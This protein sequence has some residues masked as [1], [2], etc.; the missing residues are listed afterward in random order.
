MPRR[1]NA[2]EEEFVEDLQG[3]ELMFEELD[4]LLGYR[5]RRAQ[6][7]MH[8]DYM[9]TVADLA[10][11][12][13]QT[14]TLWLINANPG[15]SQVSIAGALGMDRATMMSVTDRLEERGLLVRKRSSVDRR[16]QELYLTP[17]G[18]STLRKVKARI[19]EHESRFKALFKPAEL[20]ALLAALE[21]FRSLG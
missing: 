7:A 16:R 13:K 11:T 14:A 3:P 5:M 2:R 20:A 18:Q 21:K 19:A 17:S 8:R 12:Q 4:S 10:L 6:G 15:V 9:A 1:S